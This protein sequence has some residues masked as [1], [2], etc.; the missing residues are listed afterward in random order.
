MGQQQLLLIVAGVVV[1]GIMA[2]VGIM[3]FTD[4]AAASNRDAIANDL[5]RYASMAQEF[6]KRPSLLAGGNGSFVGFRLQGVGHNENGAYSVHS[7]SKASVQIEGDGI[8]TGYDG[9]NPVKVVMTIT[10][11]SISVAELN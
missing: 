8:E 7:P 6:H 5:V 10:P 4:S 9:A 11:D 2:A 3:M 1:V